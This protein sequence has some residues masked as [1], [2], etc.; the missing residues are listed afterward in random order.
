[1]T[2]ILF[3]HLH[4][5]DYSA[6]IRKVSGVGDEDKD[7][8]HLRGSYLPILEF[9]LRAAK[10]RMASPRGFLQRRPSMPN[11]PFSAVRFFEE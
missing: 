10:A 2:F 7:L 3:S 8:G 9:R 6:L 5:R 11:S 1:M 4:R